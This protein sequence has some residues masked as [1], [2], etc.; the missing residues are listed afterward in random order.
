MAQDPEL[1]DE[2]PERGGVNPSHELD[3]VPLYF[4]QTIEAESEAEVFRGILDSNGIPATVTGSIYPPLGFLIYV[5]R[6]RLEE[7]RRLIA[8]QRAAGPEAAAEAEA[9]S[10]KL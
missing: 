6:G 1:M 10:E 5:P 4:S 8:E 9:E 2:E 3:M 7:A